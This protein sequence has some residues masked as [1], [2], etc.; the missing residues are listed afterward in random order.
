VAFKLAKD[1]LL[2][3]GYLVLRTCN[4]KNIVNVRKKDT[5]SKRIY[6]YAQISLKWLIAN[7]GKKARKF[8]VL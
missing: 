5:A 7:R 4:Y 8:F 2:K 1:K 3:R 6:K